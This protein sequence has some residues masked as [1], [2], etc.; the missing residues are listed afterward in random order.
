MN[1]FEYQK[2]KWIRRTLL[3]HDLNIGESV[4]STKANNFFLRSPPWSKACVHTLSFRG[5]STFLLRVHYVAGVV[6][7]I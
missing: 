3:N 7:S 4:L 1:G 6:A 2:A 5:H